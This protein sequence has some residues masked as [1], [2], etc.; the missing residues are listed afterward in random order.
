MKTSTITVKGQVTIPAAVRKRF[1]LRQ[2][3]E[4]GFL[5]EDARIVLVPVQKNVEA[6]FGLVKAKRRVSLKAME[7]A[8][9]KR[10]GK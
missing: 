9:R 5:S 7:K 2:G 6:A 4:V 8:I 1:G 3:D 10:A